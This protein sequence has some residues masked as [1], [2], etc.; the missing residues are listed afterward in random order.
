MAEF[1][2]IWTSAVNDRLTIGTANSESIALHIVNKTCEFLFVVPSRLSTLC[3][4]CWVI[5]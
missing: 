1:E 3:Q 5:E 4:F 2:W